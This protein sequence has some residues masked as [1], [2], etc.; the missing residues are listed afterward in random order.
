[1]DHA[2]DGEGPLSDRS[3]G[4]EAAPDAWARAIAARR[5]RGEPI[6][7]LTPEGARGIVGVDEAAIRAAIAGAS[8]APIGDP[9][10][11]PAAR[12]AL[13][14]AGLAGDPARVVL[15]ASGDA[16]WALLLA[17]LCD[18]GDEVLAA[19]PGDP[20]L[21]ELAHLASVALVPYACR[22]DAGWAFDAA[23]LFDAIGARTRA[24][25]TAS[26]SPATGAYAD[27][28]ALEALA[29]LGVPVIVDE[30]LHHCALDAVPTPRAHVVES[31][32]LVFSIASLDA[33]LGF[34][35]LGLA[36]ITIGGPA[37][38]AAAATHRLARLAASCRPSSIVQS[39]LPSLLA[40]D[41]RASAVRARTKENLERLRAA[42]RGSAARV[43]RVEGG[44]AAPVR[45]PADRTDVE[46]AAALAEAG[47]LAAPGSRYDFPDDA[48][49][50][51]VSLLAPPETLARAAD[52]IARLAR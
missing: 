43:P 45:L 13:V 37:A 16:A 26:P 9:R 36:W 35:G 50:V 2:T 11:S 21:S 24:I 41:A 34:P 6:V 46:W 7:D 33:R 14:A 52:Q 19:A 47:V 15:G 8:L 31:E 29:S 38:E 25:A 30:R 49:Y 51:L 3:A 23:A 48:P 4:G 10:G 22:E 32:T 12:E 18:P 20:R 44:E 28:D 17:L 39:A 27:R 40:L 1:M 5:A 42:L